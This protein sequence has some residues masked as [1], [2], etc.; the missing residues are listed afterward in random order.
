MIFSAL[1]VRLYAAFIPGIIHRL[2]NPESLTHPTLR[3]AV[4]G[5]IAHRLDSNSH[6]FAGGSEGESEK[7]EGFSALWFSEGMSTGLSEGD[8]MEA[9]HDQC[10]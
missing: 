10:A 5:F 6:L 3:V 1:I 7:H 9:V 2:V 8:L 4:K